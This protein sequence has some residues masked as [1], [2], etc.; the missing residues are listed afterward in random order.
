MIEYPKALYLNGACLNVE[1][2]DN[3]ASARADGYDDWHADHERAAAPAEA[4]KAQA[5]VAP[6]P[7]PEHLAE[8]EAELREREMHLQAMDDELTARE[9][10]VAAREEAAAAAE[11]A[12]SA[13]PALPA[14][15]AAEDQTPG[16]DALKARAAELGIG[17]PPN[18]KTDKLAALVAAAQG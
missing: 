7:D 13:P 15:V 10:A 8:L 18:I 1:D 16:R 17:F 12:A 6:G 2:A 14:D 5:E 4:I 11:V 9:H 3:E